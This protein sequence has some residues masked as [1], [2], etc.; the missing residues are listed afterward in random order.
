MRF[1]LFLNQMKGFRCICTLQ[2]NNEKI[3]RNATFPSPG[4]SL[5]LLAA[6][7]RQGGAGGGAFS[8]AELKFVGNRGGSH[9]KGEDVTG[10]VT[11]ALF[12]FFFLDA[13]FNFWAALRDRSTKE[14][15]REEEKSFKYSRHFVTVNTIKVHFPHI[16]KM[17]GLGNFW[18]YVYPASL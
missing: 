6:R 11:A 9:D 15:V 4:V 17:K 5:I 12:C 16:Y 10:A 14:K 7:R 1:Q 3:K 8:K 2:Q 18:V 13:K